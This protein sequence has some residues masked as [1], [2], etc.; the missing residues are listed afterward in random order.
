MTVVKIGNTEFDGL[1]GEY[2][3]NHLVYF[4][5]DA[6]LSEQEDLLEEDLLQISYPSN[7]T[8]DIGWYGGTSAANGLFRVFVIQNY[9]WDRPFA[10]YEARSIP[11]L[12]Q[13]FAQA[14]S[15]VK[16]TLDGAKG[17]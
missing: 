4:R 17:V 6:P 8:L 2:S 12:K 10:T 14:L 1:G 15:L 3:Y 13:V 11:E 9:A 7:L 16:S 5:E